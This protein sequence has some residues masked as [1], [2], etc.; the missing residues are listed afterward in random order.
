[1]RMSAPL[2]LE[3]KKDPLPPGT[4]IMSPNDVMITSGCSAM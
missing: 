1:M 4:R 3:S 2:A